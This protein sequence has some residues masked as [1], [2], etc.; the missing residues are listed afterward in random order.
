MRI[1]KKNPNILNGKD[2]WTEIASASSAPIMLEPSKLIL[3]DSTTDESGYGNV[4]TLFG[5]ASLTTSPVKFGTHSFAFDGSG[6]Y[7]TVPNNADGRW[8][9]A[10]TVTHN[11][12]IDFWFRTP[13]PSVTQ[14][15]I[16]QFEDANNRWTITS[17]TTGI[18]FGVR[19]GGSWVIDLL[20]TGTAVTANTWTHIAVIKKGT[21]YG[22]YVDGVQL[23]YASDASTDIF[24]GSLIIGQ[25][26]TGVQYLDGNLDGIRLSK[27]NVFGASPNSGLTDTITVPTSA[28]PAGNPSL[29][30]LPLELVFDNLDSDVDE[31]YKIECLTVGGATS[32]TTR[33]RFN[34]DTGT[35]YGYR[36][37]AGSASTMSANGGATAQHDIGFYTSLGM[38][39]ASTVTISARTGLRKFALTSSSSTVSGTTVGNDRLFAQVW[40]NTNK[41]TSISISTGV[42]NG[43]GEGSVFKLFKLQ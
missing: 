4:L 30:T 22:I 32:S 25:Q 14:A 31:T 38:V 33:L 27:S 11:Y 43:L 12:T 26:G 8:N 29:T 35:N 28:P 24:N 3:N 2:I 20:P 17:Q 42:A 39:S 36:F 6:D 19:S 37:L 7:I 1:G 40:N 13:S 15:L 16:S 23:S 5:N 9:V 18:T 21:L 10:G 34:G 41:I